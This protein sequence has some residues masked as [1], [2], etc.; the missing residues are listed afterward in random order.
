MSDLRIVDL[1]KRFDKYIVVNKV[2]L[3]VS[4]GEFVVL[5]G[6]SG[7]G[8][9][10]TL[11]CIAGLEEPDEG[12]ILIDGNRVNEVAPMNRDIA[13]VFQNY[14]LYPH[15]TVF[16]N[17]A[18]PLEARGRPRDEINQ[19]VKDA[20]DLLNIGHLLKR[21]PKQLSGGEQQRVALGRA[22][23][24]NP[25]VFLMDEPLS[26]LDAKL[27]L[28]MRAELKKL[29]RRLKVT[30]IYVTHD[31]AEAVALADK[32]GV[33]NSGKIQQF[34]RPSAVYAKPANMFVAGFI[35]S[36][37][38][39]LLKA[40]VVLRDGV[41]TLQSKDFSYR[42]PSDLSHVVGGDLIDSEV[43]VGVRAED[44]E[45]SIEH[46]TNSVFQTEVNIVEPLGATALLDLKLGDETLKSIV[47]G[48]IELELGQRVWAGFAAE[49]MHIFDAMTSQ[50][51]V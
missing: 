43:F 7:C 21:K 29:Q 42:L 41:V 35:G 28:Y 1:V 10:T 49:K 30:T 39:N 19:R 40:V 25:K 50:L 47:A 33:M 23:V 22:I 11:R 15:M 26:N 38:M 36:P 45:V 16:E 2:N 20:A 9:T 12:E 17:I 3:S 51:I 13:M 6:P 24:R 34:D 8:K 5:V 18:F 46:G 48:N 31:Q 44:L 32:V 14:A 37:P 27:R 4:S